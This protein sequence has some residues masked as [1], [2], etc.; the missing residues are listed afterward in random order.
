MRHSAKHSRSSKRGDHGAVIERIERN[1]VDVIVAPFCLPRRERSA[2]AH[3]PILPATPTR[4]RAPRAVPHNEVQFPRS[5]L[6]LF[7]RPQGPMWAR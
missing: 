5:M 3:P 6:V 4:R 2:P 1:H 7:P